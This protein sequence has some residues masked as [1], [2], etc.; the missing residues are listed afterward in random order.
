MLMKGSGSSVC[1]VLEK[2]DV[3]FECGKR[4]PS[5]Q[6]EKL[7][8]SWAQGALSCIGEHQ[9]VP[10]NRVATDRSPRCSPK[11]SEPTVV[12]SLDSYDF[13]LPVKMLSSTF[14]IFAL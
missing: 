5:A 12:R 8:S 1:T 9:D 4:Q 13:H 2:D 3:S 7:W 10:H 11:S 14:P 6:L